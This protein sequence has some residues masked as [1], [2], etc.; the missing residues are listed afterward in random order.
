MVYADHYSGKFG[1]CLLGRGKIIFNNL[2]QLNI[3]RLLLHT[4]GLDERM[5][6]I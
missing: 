4:S 1:S 5:W 2:Q 3:Q 6:F